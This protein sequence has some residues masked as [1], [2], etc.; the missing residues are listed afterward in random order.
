MRRKT[1]K[2]LV[3]LVIIAAALTVGLR[4]M[5]RGWEL[6]RRLACAEQM[7]RI[8]TALK[9]YGETAAADNR[10]PL[11]SLVDIGAIRPEDLICPSSHAAN[12]VSASSG[13][14]LL[15]EPLSNHGQGA[16]VLFADG[17][18]SFV[19]AEDYKRLVP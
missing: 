18:M 1:G 16:N 12:Y 2:L 4:G 7:K 15:I 10:D 5:V 8:G 9:I 13:D 14:L 11:R 3:F 6:Q 19:P 17:H